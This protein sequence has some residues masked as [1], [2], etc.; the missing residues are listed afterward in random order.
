MDASHLVLVAS[1]DR[2]REEPSRA[3]PH[4]YSVLFHQAL[5]HGET[6]TLDE[7]AARR[8]QEVLARAPRRIE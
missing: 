4:E 8:I 7:L 3:L 2:S 1:R 6:A 5:E